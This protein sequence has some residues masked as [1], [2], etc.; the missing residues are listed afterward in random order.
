MFLR[1]K[2]ILYVQIVY[3]IGFPKLGRVGLF[4]DGFDLE[5]NRIVGTGTNASDATGRVV[6]NSKSNYIL[7]D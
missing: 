5:K 4:Q 2:Y 3:K 6:T 1:T 7:I